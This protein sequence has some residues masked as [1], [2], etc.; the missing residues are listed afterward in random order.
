MCVCVRYVPLYILIIVCVRAR[1]W[2]R[3]LIN[4]YFYTESRFLVT[5]LPPSVGRS[6]MGQNLSEPK[7]DKKTDSY[8]NKTFAVGSSCMQGWRLGERTFRAGA[9][10]VCA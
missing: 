4:N 2:V 1:A 10:G 7:T 6:V 9:L 5:C 8:E 3:E